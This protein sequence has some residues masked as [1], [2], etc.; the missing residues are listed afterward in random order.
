[1]SLADKISAVVAA[2]GA[3]LKLKADAADLSTVATSGSYGDL[4]DKPPLGTAAAHA[5]TDFATAAQGSTADSAVQPDELAAVATSGKYSDLSDKPTIPAALA[6]LD[7]TVTGA[8]LNADHTKLAGIETGAQKNVTPAWDEVTGKPTAFPPAAHTHP[9]SE[10]TGLDTAL[11][12][13]AATVHTHTQDDVTGLTAALAAKQDALGFT[14]ENPANKGTPGGY[15]SLDSAGKVPISQL[16]ASIME[17]QG[18]WNAATNTPTLADGAGDI[19]DT[20]RIT[21]G[22][23][24]N[25]GSGV[26]TWPVNGYAIYNG[27]TWEPSGSAAEGGVTTVNGLAGDVVL[28]QDEVGD[29]ATYQRFSVAEKAKL[30]G[31]AD[32][33]TANATDAALRD[34]SS[35]TGTQPVGT[36]T[37]L[38]GVATSGAYGDLL[39]TPTLGTAAATDVG[40]Y[41]TAAQGAKAD[42]AVQGDD[43]RLSD[44]RPPTAHTHPVSQVSDAT[45]VGRSL[46]TAASAAAAR[47]AI[48]AGTS[49]LVIGTSAGTAAAGNDARLSDQRT[50]SDGSVTNAKVAANAAIALSKL[51]TGNVVGSKSGTA[52]DLTVWVGPQASVPTTRDANTVYLWY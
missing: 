41:A 7:T 1:M 49:S 37:G 11:D 44:A 13:K 26:V 21:A 16:P 48:G 23:D 43:P 15:A 39:G 5:A 18:T 6:D 8:Q 42:T 27:A 35:H 17:Y 52:A 3:E 32:G 9:T 10:V 2:I 47:S 46:V 45:T 50:P 51:A 24:R 25:L 31:V 22:A 30:A 4:S 14:P 28:T 36:I 33:A 38:A 34:R 12:G 19:G 40:A 20:Y 29:G